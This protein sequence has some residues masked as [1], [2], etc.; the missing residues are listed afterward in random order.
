L[1][2]V[3]TLVGLVQ[4][5]ENL[6]PIIGVVSEPPTDGPGVHP[7]NSQIPYDYIYWLA[8]AGGRVA[9][10]LFDYP[11]NV[12]VSL[13]QSV[14]GILFTGGENTLLPSTKYF[15]TASKIFDWA[16]K[17]ND[18]GDFFPVW[19]TCQGFQL[20]S[21]LAA[22]DQSVLLHNRYDSMNYSIPLNLTNG[23]TTS[24]F[25]SS[26]PPDVVTTLTTQPVTENLHYNGVLPSSYQSNA[27]LHSFFN[28]L[29]TN[30]D[31]KGLPFGSTIEGWKYP[32]YAV[33]WHPERNQFDWGPKEG[34]V[35]TPQALRAMQ[36]VAG[37]FLSEARKNFHSFPSFAAEQGALIYQWE[38][39]FTGNEGNYPE[40]KTY[41]FPIW[42]NE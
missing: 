26:L 42:N 37:F 14:N 2:L 11:D 12:L 7:T 9:P 21:I 13:L 25:F 10:I 27:N 29:S 31:R 16:K 20:L 40:E 23:A 4:G 6:R 28:L 18:A 17:A 41:F 38:P 1:V 39:V 33:Q 36:A 8:Q 35:K 19:G 22:Q 32:F 3:V 34:L 5:R 15:Q 30:N 24:R